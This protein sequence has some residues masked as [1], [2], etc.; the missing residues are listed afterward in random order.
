MALDDP[1]GRIAPQRRPVGRDQH[2][3]DFGRPLNAAEAER[4]RTQLLARPEVAWVELNTRERRLSV[5]NDPRFASG[6]WWLQPAGGSNANALADRRRGAPGFQRA[7]ASGLAGAY[8]VVSAATRVAVLDTGITDHPELAGQML[9]GYDFVSDAEYAN[10]G[11]GRDPDPSDPGDWVSAGDLARAAFAGCTIEDSSWHGTLIAGML[12]ASTDN[13]V[14]VAAMLWNGRVLPVRVAG[15]CGATVSDI[16]DGMRWAAGLAVPG[17]PMNPNPVRIV[18]ISFGGSS[19]CG[20]AYQ[21]A[22]D[23]LRAAGVVVVAAAGN[24]NV[25][26]TRP[27]NCRGVVG[28][29]ALNRDGFKTTYSNFGAEL[30]ASGVATVGGDDWDGLWGTLLADDGL[31]SLSN[32]GT[33]GPGRA[34]YANLY[35]SSFSTPIVSGTISLMLGIQPS[36]TV[37]QIIHGLQVSARPHVVSS[38]VGACSA[39]NPGRCICSSA[40]CGAGIVDV[41]RALQWAER[42]DSYVP[43]VLTPEN[44]DADDV[45]WAAALGP[46]RTGTEPP[47]SGGG[48][49]GGSTGGG[50][51]GGSGL[52]GLAGL[53]AATLALRRSRATGRARSRAPAPGRRRRAG[54]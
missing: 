7:W 31:L 42:P 21:A 15:K 24:E 28:V 41:E 19:P 20:E 12:V 52:V 16:V 36:L 2:R 51:I 37:D 22:V 3:L 54:P 35:G 46:D 48:G 47:A 23:E 53:V 39:T 27:A 11:G 10:D 18:N 44:I 43:P 4:L 40:T 50:A 49:G 45:L 1:A 8:G 30:A 6:Q 29:V 13:G 34:S 9:P 14:G 33:L 32:D 5:P 38:V 26:P 17:V 25:G